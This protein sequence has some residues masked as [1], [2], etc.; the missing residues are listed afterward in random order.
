MILEKCEQAV[1]KTDLTRTTE[2]SQT[3]RKRE[4]TREEIDKVPDT[5]V[6]SDE[7]ENK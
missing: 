7:R 2:V 5:K 4:N 1:D 3:H 6:R